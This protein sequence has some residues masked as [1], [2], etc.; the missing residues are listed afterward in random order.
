VDSI[1]APVSGGDIGAR[2]GRLVVMCGGEENGLNAVSDVIKTYSSTI[3]LMGGAGKGQ[4]TKM[5]N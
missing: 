3:S 5:V 4:H 1:D 2:E